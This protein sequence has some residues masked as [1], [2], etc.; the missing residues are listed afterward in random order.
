MRSRVLALTATIALVGPTAL[1]F[2]R[3]GDFSA[4]FHP[5]APLV[6]A[7][8]AWVLVAT[9]ALA[10]RVPLPRDRYGRTA[11]AGMALF[12]AW[13]G[14]S[15]AWAPVAGAAVRDFEL[16]LFYL[17]AL[18]VGA[19][20]LRG[21]PVRR[22]LEPALAAGICLVMGYALGVRLLPGVIPSLRTPAADNR[23]DQPLTYW[24]A[25]GALA[26][27]GLVLCAR[28]LGDPTRSRPA[29]LLAGAASPGLAAAL[30]LT[31]SRGA[32]AAGGAAL[33]VLLLAAPARPQLR[34]VALA[35]GSGALS[36][37]AVTRFPTVA[38]LSGSEAAIE[39]HGVLFLG[40]LLALT[41]ATAAVAAG[42]LRLERRPGARAG[43]LAL[44]RWTPIATTAMLGL[45]VG[46][47]VY[48]GL[49]ERKAPPRPKTVASA[50]RLARVDSTRY[51]YWRVAVDAFGDEPVRGLGASGFAV[52]W[53]RERPTEE[54]PR[55][56]HS[57]ELETAANLGL[58]GLAAL[59]MLL[60]G[61]VLAAVRAHRRRPE[62]V[63]GWCAA[64][65]V[66]LVHSAI[67]WDWEMPA[68]TLPALLL[69]A[70]LVGVAEES[71]SAPEAEGEA[72]PPARA[73]ALLER[74]RRL[75]RR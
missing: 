72:P 55:R 62:L 14:A 4:A 38:S 67:D 22:R 11:L 9:V 46:A 52:A 68:V 2:R 59:L 5:V 29:R 12:T 39:R 27:M 40:V 23:L 7:I 66:W 13:T 58:V 43:R 6:A 65:T 64:A 71:P 49:Q 37:F 36:V 51:A 21:P 44:P 30:Y 69:A 60:A 18:L 41:L 56:A 53:L 16:A 26:A 17:A 42:L 3:G 50:A 35:V 75:A 31:Y 8:V 1:A 74:G 20:A 28:I 45:V 47:L 34:A 24:N 54:T 32:L 33:L 25:E 10:A 61:T 19:A 70:A 63:A 73:P 48:A 15:I 57:L